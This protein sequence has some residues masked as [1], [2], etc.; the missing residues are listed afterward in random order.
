MCA[1]VNGPV[2]LPEKVMLLKATLLA[3][4]EGSKVTLNEA[5]AQASIGGFICCPGVPVNDNVN[6][7]FS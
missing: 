1:A 7:A 3:E 2:K 5:V 6:G 4:E